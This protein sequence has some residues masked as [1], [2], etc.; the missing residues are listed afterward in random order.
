MYLDRFLAQETTGLVVLHGYGNVMERTLADGESI[1]VEPGGFLY[2]DAAVTMATTTIS[3][4]PEGANAGVQ[5]VKGVA[6]R[7][8]A[9]IKA[10]RQLT[11]GGDGIG[12]LLSSG[13]LQAAAGVFTGSGMTL[14]R[15]SGP[16]RV[17]IQSMYTHHG[18]A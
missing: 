10:A 4:T 18:T 3:L 8:F 2:K 5:A 15:L 1:L 12:G 16:G 13:G 7:G 17:G 14:M 9:A 6:S 11:K